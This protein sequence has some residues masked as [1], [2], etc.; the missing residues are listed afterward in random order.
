MFDQFT[1]L[2]ADASTWAY[3]V[4][5]VFALLDAVFPVVPSETAVITAGV[6]AA[7]GDLFL[8]LVLGCAAAGAF[9]GD[10]VGYLIG[11][12]YGAWAQRRFFAGDKGTRRVA[13]AR[14]QLAVRGAELI[15]VG[16]FV[17][18]GRTAVTVTAGTTRYPWPRFARFDLLAAALWSTYATMLGFLGGKAFQDAPWNG[19]VLALVVALLITVLIEAARALVRRLR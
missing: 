17:P 9:A 7:G 12:R 3:V 2:V 5:L 19:L 15:V 8:P 10:N 13:W 14:R 16:R 1:H 18:G 6:V 4:L 11:H